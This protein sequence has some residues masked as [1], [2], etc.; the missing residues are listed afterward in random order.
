MLALTDQRRTS[1]AP[2]TPRYRP[3]VPYDP[4][5]ARKA[6]GMAIAARCRI[7]AVGNGFYSVPSQSGKNHYMVTLNPQYPDVP[8]CNCPDYEQR[9]EPCN[10]VYALR[11]VVERETNPDGSETVTQTVTV[12]NQTTTAPRKT[13]KQ[14]WPAYNAAQTQE[15]T[16]FERLL[17]ELC[18][19]V[20]EPPRKPGPGRKPI[21][22]ADQT[23]AAVSNVYSTVSARRFM[24]DLEEAHQKGY[25]SKVP[26]FNAISTAL[27]D[28]TIT[29]ILRAMIVRACLP[30]KAIEVDFAADSSGFGTSRFVRWFDEKYGKPRQKAHWVKVHV[31]TGVRTN[32]VTSVEVE[33]QYAHDCPQFL[34][35]L[36]TTAKHFKSRAKSRRMPPTSRTRTWTQPMRSGQCR[37]SRSS[38]TPRPHLAARWPRCSTC[39][40]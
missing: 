19:G 6:R 4:T 17:Y 35:L 20:Q 2:T 33:G 15:R 16:R 40:A 37:I 9:G 23:F 30:L 10:H 31:M 34:P 7:K 1:L 14:N 3:G 12:T 11:Y 5:E 8:R 13:Y 28:E 36:E 21:P 24:C 39:S 38:A 29:P 25:I 27:E 26:H 18:Q 32:V 22:L